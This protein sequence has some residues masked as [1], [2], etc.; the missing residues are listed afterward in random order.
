MQKTKIKD[1][2]KRKASKRSPEPENGKNVKSPPKPT[3]ATPKKKSAS[4]GAVTKQNKV[5]PASYLPPW[6][7]WSD[8]IVNE[9][10]CA[11]TVKTIQPMHSIVSS[12][13]KSKQ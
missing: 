8:D 9:E 4:R 1:R 11:I 7:E 10:L 12:L 13:S 3:L 2:S 6:P 5:I